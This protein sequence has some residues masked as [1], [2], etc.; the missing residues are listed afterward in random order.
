[1]ADEQRWLTSKDSSHS[2]GKPTA[3]VEACLAA[4]TMASSLRLA[5]DCYREL[6]AAL[7]SRWYLLSRALSF[8]RM[9]EKKWLILGCSTHL[10]LILHILFKHFHVDGT[11]RSLKFISVHFLVSWNTYPLLL[12]YLPLFLPS[13]LSIACKEKG[14]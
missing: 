12:I 5:S 11:L 3:P 1:M 4:D 10:C 9:E 14:L 6:F 8:R 7:V 13:Y 2:P